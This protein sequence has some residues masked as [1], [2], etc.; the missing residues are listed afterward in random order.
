MVDFNSKYSGGISN[1]FNKPTPFKNIQ[2]GVVLTTGK[3]AVSTNSKANQNRDLRFNADEHA[4]RCRV[5]G[6]QYD[7]DLTTDELPNC[8]PLL[9]KH[10]N[11]V[12]KEREVVLVITFGEDEKHSDR[13][14]I[15]PIISSL[16]KLNFD[17]T[18]G[19]AMSNLAVGLTSPAVNLDR[20]PE[21][22]GIYD[23]PQNLIIE[24]R[25]NTDIIQR[26]NEIL[27]RSGK[28]VINKPLVF[29][30][31]NPSFI[32]I[33]SDMSYE[34]DNGRVRNNVSVTNIVSDKINLLTYK[35]GAPAFNNLTKVVNRKPTYI[36][37]EELQNI[38]NEAHPLVFGDTLV[39]YLQL[40]KAALVNHVHN[41]NGNKPTDR[42]DTGTLPLKEFLDQAEQLEKDML[43]KNIRIN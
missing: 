19:T 1:F 35:D 12:P 32:Q 27:I 17:S 8:F 25:N 7:N 4:I 21:A 39:S 11:I 26:D 41:G 2:L 13:F 5:L 15:G 3:V 14:Y 33:N 28:F 38:L 30:K 37:N 20:L 22:D 23:D 34:E 10:L 29:N 43:S 24:G 42:T 18:D 40:F 6:S 16:D 9:P 31:E 36:D